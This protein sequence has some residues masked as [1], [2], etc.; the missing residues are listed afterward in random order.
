MAY[1][2][3]WKIIAWET[4]QAEPEYWAYMSWDQKIHLE[5]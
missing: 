2:T 1:D 4:A 3:Q 5:E